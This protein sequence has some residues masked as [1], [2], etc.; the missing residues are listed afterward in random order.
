[1]ADFFVTNRAASSAPR[2]ADAPMQ[3][4]PSA[5]LQSLGTVTPEDQAALLM[6]PPLIGGSDGGRVSGNPLASEEMDALMRMPGSQRRDDPGASVRPPPGQEEEPPATVRG[7]IVREA[8]RGKARS[9]I[10]LGY[11]TGVGF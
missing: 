5:N 1:M 10:R 8:M 11:R 2:P 3:S 7:D 4:P 6:R 9:N